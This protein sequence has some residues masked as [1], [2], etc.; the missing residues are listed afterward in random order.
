MSEGVL[1]VL[2]SAG[3]PFE[4]IWCCFE[5]AIAAAL[6]S[7]AGARKLHEMCLYYQNPRRMDRGGSREPSTLMTGRMG[8]QCD[9]T[10]VYGD[11]LDDGSDDGCDGVFLKWQR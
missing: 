11:E 10:C 7:L 6:E 5:E 8:S 1:L 4:R 9:I 3:T 2:D